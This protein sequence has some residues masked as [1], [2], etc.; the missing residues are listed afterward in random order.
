VTGFEGAKMTDEISSNGRNVP[1]SIEITPTSV[2][3][4]P[5]P[6]VDLSGI[7]EKERAELLALY[8]SKKLDLSIKAIEMGVDIDALRSTMNALGN[9]TNDVAQAGN[10]VT[11]THTQ[12]T[13]IGRTEIIMGN[14]EQAA[15]GK[16]SKSQSGGRDLTPYYVIGGLIAL[17]AVAALI[18]GG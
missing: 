2:Q 8:N 17:V 6:T 4:G 9:T 11:V 16:L 14:T 12:E 5:A 13:S 1:V 18:G 7:G 3:F 15:T 10:S